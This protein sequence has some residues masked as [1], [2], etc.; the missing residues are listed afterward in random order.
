MTAKKTGA[1]PLKP[2]SASERIQSIDVLRGLTILAMIFVNDLGDAGGGTKGLPGWLHHY[3]WNLDGMTWVDVIFPAFMYIVGMSI[4]FAIGRRF[5]RGEKPLRIWGHI[6]ARTAS[7]V[8]LGI[9]MVNGE[10]YIVSDNGLLPGIVWKAAMFVGIFCAWIY[11]PSEPGKRRLTLRIVRWAGISLL[12]V[13]ALIHRPQNLEIDGWVR[14]RPH[15]WGI[16]GLIAWA[17]FVA[18]VVFALFRRNIEFVALSIG[19]L[20]CLYI[21]DSVSR[22]GGVNWLYGG[23]PIGIALGSHAAISVTGLLHGMVLKAGK[24]DSP[25]KRIRWAVVFGGIL[26]ILAVWTHRLS[27]HID[28]ERVELYQMFWYNKT[29]AT[30]PW[31]L[32]SS[33]WTAWAWAAVHF[34]LEVGKVKGWTKLVQPA[35]ENPLFAYILQPAIYSF[36]GVALLV[37]PALNPYFMWNEYPIAALIRAALFALFVTW[38]AG[39][40][41]KRGVFMKV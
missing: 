30:V 9:F 23:Q 3:P 38:F 21:A 13:L 4:P 1:K 39:W 11:V 19:L 29:W 16:L 37:S 2:S 25:W 20:Y 36:F 8:A 17:Y 31:C 5:E 22:I 27:P 24:G 10:S 32:M 40:L 34:L 28:S 41:K 33:A 35:G 14:L 15:W 6:T 18:C 12:V 26:A 7:L